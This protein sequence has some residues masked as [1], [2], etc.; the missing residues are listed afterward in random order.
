M[1]TPAMTSLINEQR[2]GFVAT[3]DPDG[4]PSVSPKATFVVIDG[5]R[6]AFGDI[7]SPRTVSNLRANN[8]VEVSFVDPFVRKGYRFKGTA[9]IAERGTDTYERYVG[10]F[11]AFGETVPK[12]RNLIV[13][14]VTR[15]LAVTSPSYDRGQSESDLRRLWTARFRKL[16]PGGDFTA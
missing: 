13:I 5:T 15:A 9:E 7:R 6:I 1:L 2:L 8:S 3:V 16:Q 11:A 4:S 14:T 10:L 12:M